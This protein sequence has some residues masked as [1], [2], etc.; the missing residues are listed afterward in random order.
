[1]ASSAEPVYDYDEQY[2]QEEKLTEVSDQ[3]TLGI[4]HGSEVSQQIS[5]A[6]HFP[7]SIA[8]FRKDAFKAVTL[9]EQTAAE[10]I[11]AIPRDGKVIE[12]PSARFAEILANAWTNCRC[13]ARVVGED[14]GFVTAQGVFTDLQQNVSY[15]YEVRRR[16]SDSKGRRYSADMIQTT[17]NAVCSI[18]LRNAI[19]KGIPKAYWKG[20]YLAAKQ[21]IVGKLETLASRRQD[22]IALFKAYGVS[23][24]MVYRVLGVKGIGDITP[25]HLVVLNGMLTSLESGESTVEQMFAAPDTQDRATAEK[26]SRTV[27]EIKA[28]YKKAGS[29]PQ[30]VIVDVGENLDAEPPE[31]VKIAA[32]EAQEKLQA[33]RGKPGAKPTAVKDIKPGLPMDDF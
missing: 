26:S 20:L 12:G 28:K 29:P 10:C 2:S 31:P 25:D 32:Q 19:L 11:Y 7:R 5:T 22:K 23:A 13:G 4:L 18:A 14:E 17:A 6:K 30:E 33:K 16:I 9:D 1:M 27:E 21:T 24:D 15:S 8:Q 3:G